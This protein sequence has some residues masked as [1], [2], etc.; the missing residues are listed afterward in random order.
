MDW[1]DNTFRVYSTQNVHG[2]HCYTSY[3]DQSSENEVHIIDHDIEDDQDDDDDEEE[4]EEEEEK[5]SNGSDDSVSSVASDDK[6]SIPFAISPD[7]ESKCAGLDDDPMHVT[8]ITPDDDR[9]QG[10]RRPSSWVVRLQGSDRDVL[11]YAARFMGL[12]G[13][14]YPVQDA[15][16]NLF[17]QIISVGFFKGSTIALIEPAKEDSKHACKE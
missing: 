11:V 7:N 16:N 10:T 9:I 1:N 14:S 12:L 5:T 13:P 3:L 15:S 17:G 4:E 2:S 8:A 6:E